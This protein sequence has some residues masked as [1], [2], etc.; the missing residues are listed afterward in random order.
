M[1]VSWLI[2]G[3]DPNHLQTVVILQVQTNCLDVSST[4]FSLERMFRTAEKNQ[5]F[6]NFS[7]WN[8][9]IVFTIL[10][11]IKGVRSWVSMDS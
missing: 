2:N 10:Y 9:V 5:K 1:A 7:R 11:P 8:R 4:T 3:G 6:P